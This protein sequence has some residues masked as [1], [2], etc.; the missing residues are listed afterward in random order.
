MINK[1]RLKSDE[2]KA[3][4]FNGNNINEVEKFTGGTVSRARHPDAPYKI[5]ELR[6]TFWV[7]SYIIKHKNRNFGTLPERTF[8]ELYDEVME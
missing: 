6:L 4:L 7:G 2:V 1:Y 8:H 5:E 3:V